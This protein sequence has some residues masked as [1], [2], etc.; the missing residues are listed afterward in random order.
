MEN[1]Q[2]QERLTTDQGRTIR[3]SQLFFSS[4]WFIGAALI[5]G[6]YL[7][8]NLSSSFAVPRIIGW[9]YDLCG[10]VIGS[11]IQLFLT[12]IGIVTSFSKRRE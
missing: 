12:G 2:K 11:V 6:L 8:N 3:W 4:L 1:N 7:T 10:V 9:I 5:L